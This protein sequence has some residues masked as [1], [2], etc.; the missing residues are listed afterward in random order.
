[1]NQFISR[2]SA[3][4]KQWDARADHNKTMIRTVS[5]TARTKHTS[6]LGVTNSSVTRND[7]NTLADPL[8]WLEDNVGTVSSRTRRTH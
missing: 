7:M 1:M 8:G 3:V 4:L 6:D 5:N 2:V